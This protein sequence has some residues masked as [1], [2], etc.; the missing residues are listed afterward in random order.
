MLISSVA[1][2][3]T[4]YEINASEACNAGCSGNVS[5]SGF[6]EMDSLGTGLSASNISDWELT[7]TSQQHSGTVLNSSNGEV[8]S[9][10]PYS[11][12]ATATELILTMP[13]QFDPESAV[14][15]FVDTLAFPYIVNFQYQSGDGTEPA[16]IMTN[17]PGGPVDQAYSLFDPSGTVIA[18]VAVPLPSTV[19]LFIAAMLGAGWFTRR[20]KSAV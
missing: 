4:V 9:I 1:I 10:G 12:T 8:L 15:A 18:S 6:I 3:G 20:H 13:Q 19:W 14:F 11:L 2:A 17:A 16:L 5:V 7:F